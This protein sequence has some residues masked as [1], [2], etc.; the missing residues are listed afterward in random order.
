[1][2]I[3][4]SRKQ[5]SKLYLAWIYILLQV[6]IKKMLN[7]TRKLSTFTIG[8]FYQNINIANGR[9]VVIYQYIWIHLVSRLSVTNCKRNQEI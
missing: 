1:M 2:K 5:L 3:Y 9:N 7:E 6:H 8:N 4:S